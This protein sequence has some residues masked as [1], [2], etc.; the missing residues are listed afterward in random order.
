[1]LKST[2]IHIP[3]IGKTTEELLWQNNVLNWNDFLDNHANLDLS[4]DKKELILRFIRTS[5]KQYDLNNHYFFAS[6]LPTKEHWRAYN[7]F[8]CCRRICKNR[9]NHTN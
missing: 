8:K 2:F 7:Y 1:M 5:K 4:R 9:G 6:N 3:G